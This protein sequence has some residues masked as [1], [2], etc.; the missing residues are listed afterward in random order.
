MWTEYGFLWEGVSDKISGFSTKWYY[1]LDRHFPLI[2]VIKCT[3]LWD[4]SSNTLVCI[5][6]T[7][8]SYQLILRWSLTLKNSRHLSFIKMINLPSCKILV[9]T[10]HFAFSLQGPE[11]R[12]D[13]R[14]TLYHNMS[15]LWRANKNWIKM[16]WDS[17]TNLI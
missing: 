3:K 15:S 5:L 10:V 12:T 14:M 17:F 6:P 16:A 11:R 1:D 8:F 2:M 13:W 7:M 9:L 4:P